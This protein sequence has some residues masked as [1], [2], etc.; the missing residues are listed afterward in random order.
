MK[1]NLTKSYLLA[2]FGKFENLL[3]RTE[4]L[5]HF[6][7]LFLTHACN[8]VV[9]VKIFFTLRTYRACQFFILERERRNR[10]TLTQN[11]Q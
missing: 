6:E 7:Q 4:N 2:D 5:L 3:L 11:C 1:D 10:L 9:R 8:E